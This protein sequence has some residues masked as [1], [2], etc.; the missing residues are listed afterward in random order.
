MIK[1]NGTPTPRFP[2]TF[3]VVLSDLDDGATTTRTMDG[4]LH[5]DRIAVKR[6]ITLKFNFLL[7]EELST[8]LKQMKEVF[9]DVEYP[10]PET[11]KSETKTFYVGNRTAPVAQYDDT[12]NIYWVDISFN[13]IER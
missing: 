1:I 12:G 3:S 11:G 7:W 6:K 10:D 9:F 2:S 13:F 4:V 8:L 5:R